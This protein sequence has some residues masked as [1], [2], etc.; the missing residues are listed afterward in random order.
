MVHLSAN[1]VFLYSNNQI[2]ITLFDIFGKEVWKLKQFSL[3]RTELKIM[4]SQNTV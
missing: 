4:T 3:F 2:T 1:S